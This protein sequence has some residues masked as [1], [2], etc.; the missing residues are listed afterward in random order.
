MSGPAPRV[1]SNPA[2]PAGEKDR[3][4]AGDVRRAGGELLYRD[5]LP[6]QLGRAACPFRKK[7]LCQLQPEPGG[8]HP[9]LCGR[10]HP[11][12][13]QRG[14]GDRGPPHPPRASGAGVPVQRPGPGGPELLAGRERGGGP[15]RHHRR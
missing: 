1:Q 13:S 6:C 10:L 12:G 14:A 3:P 2:L 5:P 7:Y 9:H 15:R 4:A 8:R 11:A